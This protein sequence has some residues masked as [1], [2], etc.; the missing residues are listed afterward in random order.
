MTMRFEARELKSYAEPISADQLREGEV[1]FFLTF[2]DDKML[3]PTM[4]TVAFVGRNLEPGD[5]DRV[6]FQDIESF[7][8]GVR[9]ETALEDNPAV[10]HCGSQKELGHVFDFQHALDQLLA[11][12]VRRE[13]A[14]LNSF[15]K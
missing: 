1:Y 4:E 15:A 8:R 6:Y 2:L 3:I 12:A 7:A 9:Y 13:N 5:E 11:C 10:F 14:A